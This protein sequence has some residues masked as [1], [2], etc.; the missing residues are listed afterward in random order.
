MTRRARCLRTA[1]AVLALT[2]APVVLAAQQ[3][4]PFQRGVNS[5]QL[6]FDGKRWYV[7][8]IFWEAETPE[9]PIPAELLRR[10]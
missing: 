7:V 9:H 10:P 4:A 3:A 5:F 6:W 2:M 8:S 1:L